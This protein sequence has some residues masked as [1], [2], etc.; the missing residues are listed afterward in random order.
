MHLYVDFAV[1]TELLPNLSSYQ[2]AHFSLDKI[3]IELFLFG[4]IRIEIHCY[5][6]IP[7]IYQNCYLYCICLLYSYLSSYI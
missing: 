5:F 6:R 4:E 7:W 3:V 1:V 2:E